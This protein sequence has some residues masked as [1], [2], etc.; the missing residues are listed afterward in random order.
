MTCN[1]YDVLVYFK[2]KW[3]KSIIFFEYT[4]IANYK[5][6]DAQFQQGYVRHYLLF[7]RFVFVLKC[8]WRPMRQNLQ[9]VINFLTN[10]RGSEAPSSSNNTTPSSSE[11]QS[12]PGICTDKH[13][14]DRE[15]IMK[16]AAAKQLIERYFY[17][18]VD[19]CGNSNCDNQYCASSGE[20]GFDT[21]QGISQ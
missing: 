5:Y 20:V 14:S 8:T 6:Y 9:H 13:S 19:G 2:F 4:F 15:D 17:Q 7:S 18:L 11:E 12:H 16:R 21:N 1:E 3:V 10:F